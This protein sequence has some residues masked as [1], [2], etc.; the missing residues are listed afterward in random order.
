MLNFR[1]MSMNFLLGFFRWLKHLCLY[2]DTKY[3]CKHL[4]W[5]YTKLVFFLEK[6]LLVLVIK[7]QFFSKIEFFVV[8]LSW[9]INLLNY[10]ISIFV[11]FHVLIIYLLIFSK[12]F[13]WRNP[14]W[15]LF[16]IGSYHNWILIFVKDSTWSLL[17]NWH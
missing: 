6:I 9:L 2:R 5:S 16:W 3:K 13:Y 8:N 4:G 7:H 10:S 14:N 15:N 17:L 1:S 12:L 11:L